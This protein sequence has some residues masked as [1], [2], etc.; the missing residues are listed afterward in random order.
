[1]VVARWGARRTSVLK[2]F[3]CPGVQP[4]RLFRCLVGRRSS[5]RGI[6]SFLEKRFV[7]GCKKWTAPLFLPLTSCLE[8]L[9]F[10]C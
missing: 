4:F 7:F 1:M 2:S 8:H 10:V 5:S 3:P 9:D 6:I